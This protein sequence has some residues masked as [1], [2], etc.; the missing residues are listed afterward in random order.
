[1]RV[2]KLKYIFLF[3]IIMAFMLSC[4]KGDNSKVID[5]EFNRVTCIFP[6][7]NSEYW[8]EL[9]KGIE[10]NI[11]KEPTIDIKFYYQV[12]SKNLDKIIFDLE[13]AYASIVNVIVVADYMEDLEYKKVIKK[14]K[15]KGIIVILIKPEF[16]QFKNTSQ[17][18]NIIYNQIVFE[19][20]EK[21]RVVEYEI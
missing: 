20:K 5:K 16:F 8:K 18:G 21:E 9:A 1:M 2:N 7:D 17:I 12:V 13:Y 19:L 11:D 6:Q 14:A 4:Y 15:N 3:I 10:N